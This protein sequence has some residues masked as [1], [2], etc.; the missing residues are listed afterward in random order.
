MIRCELQVLIG[1]NRL[2]YSLFILTVYHNK[3]VTFDVQ[4]KNDSE[5]CFKFRL[6]V[7][8]LKHNYFIIFSHN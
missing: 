6:A 7:E 2:V 4:I 5:L 3:E 1:L 8:I